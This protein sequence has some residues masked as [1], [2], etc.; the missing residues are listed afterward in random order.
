M[1]KIINFN[2]IV[3]TIKKFGGVNCQ[4]PQNDFFGEIIKNP[5]REEGLVM[6][7]AYKKHLEVCKELELVKEDSGNLVLTKQGLEYYDAIKLSEN[8]KKIIDIKTNELKEKLIKIIINKSGF[9]KKHTEE[10]VID[11][12]IN[13]GETKFVISKSESQ[14][15]SKKFRSLLEDLELITFKNNEY[16]ISEKIATEF[17][18]TRTRPQ[19]AKELRDILKLQEENGEKSEEEAVKY[20]KRRLK[21]LGVKQDIT[22][23]VKRISEINTREG[24]DIVSFNGLGS[25]KYDRF[26]EVK[27]TTGSYPIFYW[28]ENERLVAEKLGDEYFLYIYINFGK[29]GQR[30]IT[31]IKNPYHEIVG[32]KHGSVHEI[33]TWRVKWDGKI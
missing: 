20:E 1:A 26:I 14:K 7:T 12:H 8:G 32:E 21:D 33:T 28:S 31:P 15:I 25:L 30:L 16:K 17:S 23:R 11:I 4:M 13:N 9:I 24:Y 6:V 5:Q 2:K 19:S 3:C 27:S 10:G 22:D 18:K 29:T